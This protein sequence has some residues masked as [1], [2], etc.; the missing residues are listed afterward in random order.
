VTGFLR[1]RDGAM[2]PI[3]APGALQT[4]VKAINDAGEVVGYYQ[5]ITATHGFVLDANGFVTIDAPGASLTEV[6]G[7]NN[8]GE[9]AGRFDDAKGAHVFMALPQ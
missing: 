3:Q 4:F 1:Q 9:L 6:T 2:F 7:I 8:H 5:T